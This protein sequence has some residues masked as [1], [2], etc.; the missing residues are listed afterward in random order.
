MSFTLRVSF[1][2]MCLFVR[3]GSQALEVL[4]PATG[5]QAGTGGCACAEPHAPR[6]IFDSAHLRP[7]Q[8]ANDDALVHCSLAKKSLDFGDLGGTLDNSLPPE[9]AKLGTVRSDVLSGENT[10]LVASR[11]R[12]RNGS[13]SDYSR[14]AC[15]SW[16][17]QVQRLSHVIEWSIPDVPGDSLQLPLQSLTGVSIGSVPTLYPVNGVVELEVWHAPHSE[18]PPD[19]VIPPQPAR[20]A[21]APHFAG[22]GLLL[23]AEPTELPQYEPDACAPLTNPGKYDQDPRGTV[24]YSCT[25]AEGF[26]P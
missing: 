8:S 10:D 19:F 18:L 3:D 21:F 20:G 1:H 15:W 13:C 12:V 5:A 24:T 26:T 2:G 4:M 14:G 25:S 17:G 9:L 11:V 16:Q 22:F 7:S 23:A 6:L